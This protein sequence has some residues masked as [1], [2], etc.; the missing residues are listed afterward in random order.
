MFHLSQMDA[1]LCFVRT[2][3]AGKKGEERGD[4]IVQTAFHRAD[5]SMGH[6]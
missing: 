4:L 3:S 2:V 6:V 1:N 5:P